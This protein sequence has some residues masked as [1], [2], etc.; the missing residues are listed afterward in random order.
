MTGNDS[1]AVQEA[2]R[3]LL[4]AHKDLQRASKKNAVHLNRSLK[5]IEGGGAVRVIDAATPPSALRQEMNDALAAL[6]HS[7]HQLRLAAMAKCLAHGISIGQLGRA[8]G[9][10]RQLAHRYAREARAR[11][12]RTRES[13]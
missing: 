1:E 3:E 8:W 5:R 10:S 12:Y 7:R 4:Q 6:E 9:I 2:I 13:N 11:G